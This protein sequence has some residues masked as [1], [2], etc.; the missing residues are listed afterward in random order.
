M[1]KPNRF[2]RITKSAIKFSKPKAPKTVYTN[3]KFD[4]DRH[5]NKIAE[6][7]EEKQ[8]AYLKNL[9]VPL[10]DKKK[11]IDVLLEIEREKAEEN[12]KKE[13]EESI[14][15]RMKPRVIAKNR[16]PYPEGLIDEIKRLV[17]IKDIDG[18][19]IMT[20]DEICNA[21]NVNQPFVSNNSGLTPDE[22]RLRAQ[23]F[24]KTRTHK[25]HP[26][27]NIKVTTKGKGTKHIEY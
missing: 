27:R 6:L 7:S 5:L 14:E 24:A 2:T 21:V 18:N 26:T 22:R 23:F 16:E 10:S 17:N 25:S 9:N 19:P 3:H 11:I 4:I 15:E 13:Q 1:P 12:N 8:V 20:F